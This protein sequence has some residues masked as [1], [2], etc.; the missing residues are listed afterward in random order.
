MS[1][2][3]HPHRDLHQHHSG[4]ARNWA[5]FLAIVTGV[6]LIASSLWPSGATAGEQAAREMGSLDTAYLVRIIA[7]VLAIVAVAVAQGWR[8]RSVARVML[9]GIAAALLVSVALLDDFG[10][11]SLLTLLVPA[12]LF[13][14][15]AVG[16]GPVHLD[17]G[18]RA[19][20]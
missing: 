1:T 13:C 20:R 3:V 8:R 5:D 6:A 4:R 18:T 12:T 16:L 19:P 11:R 17:E 14:V 2:T 7:G 15:A 9:F 10:P